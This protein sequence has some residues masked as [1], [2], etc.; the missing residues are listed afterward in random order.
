MTLLYMDSFDHYTDLS[1]KYDVTP[2]ASLKPYIDT[3]FGR[4]VNGSLQIQD[5]T[6]NEIVKYVTESDELIVGMAVYFSGT[7][8]WIL[9]LRGA[10]SVTVCTF[11]ANGTGGEVW[12]GLQGSGTSLGT[13]TGEF[14]TNTW[15]WLEVRIKRHATLG[16]IEVRVNESVVLSGTAL[17]TGAND[18]AEIFL[19][20]ESQEAN[21]VWLD[22]L[23]VLNTT[24]SAPQN[25]FLGDVRV[26]V[27]RPKANGT[28]SDFTPTGEVSN[29]LTTDD[30]L[31]DGDATYVEAGQIG[32]KEDYDTES[33]A[34]LGISPGT[35]FGAQV[36]NAVKKTD[37]GTLRYKNQMVVAGTTY[38]TGSEITATAVDYKMTTYIRD[39]DPS[40][41]AAWTEA[42]IAAVG[43]GVEITYRDI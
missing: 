14:T 23:Y 38:D 33:M 29:Y 20:S 26:T 28:N 13:F 25:T 18:F 32:A 43:P 17:N 41:D 21:N 24:G 40:D 5:N 34:D 2:G 3:T 11:E 10:D 9:R 12:R 31:H 22:D 4:F 37:A 16:E 39:T 19:R 27:T 36:V 35:I 6:I 7:H 15:Q 1:E 42:K 8:N 30:A